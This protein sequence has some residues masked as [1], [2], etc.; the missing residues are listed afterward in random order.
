[1][2]S[3]D[4][5]LDW[6]TVTG[7]D[8]HGNDFEFASICD[9]QDELA[10]NYNKRDTKILGYAGVQ[11]GPLF[12]GFRNDENWMCRISGFAANA[13]IERLTWLR[14]AHIT[15]CDYQVTVKGEFGTDYIEKVYQKCKEA[16]KM[17][18]QLPTPTY[19]VSIRGDTLYL[20]KR[21]EPVYL[22]LYD[23]GGEQGGP[24]GKILR[25]EVEYKKGASNPAWRTFLEAP[26][27]TEHIAATVKAEF[28]KRGVCAQFGSAYGQAIV[29]EKAHSDVATQLSWLDRCVRPVVDRLTEAGYRDDVRRILFGE[30]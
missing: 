21:D 10:A 20:G 5:A 28:A 19:W 17:N 26:N 6:L 23:K 25:W 13:A 4:S 30:I 16:K 14:D 8:A 2:T 9:W 29:A 7:K 3:Y 22:R 1:M 12:L 11:C 27:R 24:L 18:G 15:R